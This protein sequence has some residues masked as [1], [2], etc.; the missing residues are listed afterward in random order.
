MLGLQSGQSVGVLYDDA[1][2]FPGS[3]DRKPACFQFLDKFLHAVASLV[4][5]VLDGMP[6]TGEAFQVGGIETE[7]VRLGI[8]SINSELG[9]L[10]ILSRCEF[11]CPRLS[12]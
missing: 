9:R 6:D 7:E 8:A 1:H 2:I 10:I 3:R 4:D 11:E 5:T 12:R